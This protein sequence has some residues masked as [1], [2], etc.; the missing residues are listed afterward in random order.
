VLCLIRK[1]VLFLQWGFR[2]RSNECQA[3]GVRDRHDGVTVGTGRQFIDYTELG[4]SQRGS[5]ESQE[6]RVP[7]QGQSMAYQ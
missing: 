6:G 7:V 4:I 3:T 1:K 5:K 2:G